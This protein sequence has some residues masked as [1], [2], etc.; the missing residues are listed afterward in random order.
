ME[1]TTESDQQYVRRHLSQLKVLTRLLEHELELSKGD[2]VVL[3]K[4]LVE[5]SLDTLEIFVEDCEMS[6]GGARPATAGASD[7][8]TVSAATDGKPQVTRLN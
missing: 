6:L 5:N 8:K 4:T 3:D 1:R 2:E 7:R